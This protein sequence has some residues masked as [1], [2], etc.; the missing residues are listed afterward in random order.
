MLWLRNHPGRPVT[1]ADVAEIFGK[2]YSVAA[3]YGNAASAFAKTGINPFNPDIFTDADF[4]AADVTDMPADPEVSTVA[5]AAESSSTTPPADPDVSTVAAAAE[6]SSTT[7]PADPEAW[8]S[9][10]PVPKLQ[11]LT[12]GRKRKVAHAVIATSSPFKEQLKKVQE[13]KDVKL[14]NMQERKRKREEK[15]KIT[16]K[17][18][19]GHK[20]KVR[21]V[22]VKADSKK[23]KTGGRS[24]R[25]ASAHA[26]DNEPELNNVDRTPC[27]FCEVIYCESS[28]RWF[29]CKSC[30][31][32]AC[33]D[34]AA[35]GRKTMFVCSNCK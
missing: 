3:N 26:K 28:V 29:R 8:T 6:S 12:K 13:Q 21:K 17:G 35:V 20:T 5:P 18:G 9:L 27:M 22:E 24:A 7:P 30:F 14:L 4:L 11:T 10:L 31:M 15:Q 2:V 34:C 1:E 25:K 19:S 33:G 16:E 23:S 32:W